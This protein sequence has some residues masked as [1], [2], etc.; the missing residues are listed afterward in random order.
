MKQKMSKENPMKSKKQRQRM[1][2]NNPMKNPE[3]A[4]KFK[5]P[6][7]EET[8]KKIS[9]KPV[10]KLKSKITFLKEVVENTS[11][12]YSR[13]FITKFETMLFAGLLLE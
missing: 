2:I 8:K 9:L 3:I 11:I 1:S 12:G 13:S 7:S 4:Q 10:C 6:L 5:H